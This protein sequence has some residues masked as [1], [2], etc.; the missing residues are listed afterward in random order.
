MLL[1]NLPPSSPK[2]LPVDMQGP[3]VP[4]VRS[5]D[6]PVHPIHGVTGGFSELKSGNCLLTAVGEVILLDGGLLFAGA[7]MLD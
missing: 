5:F 2:L 3:E 4:V 7:D 6:L 1:D